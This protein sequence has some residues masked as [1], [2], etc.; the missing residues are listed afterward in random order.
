MNTKRNFL[1]T[2]MSLFAMIVISSCDKNDDDN[3]DT[4]TNTISAKWEI[5]DSNSAYASFEFNKDG[6]YIVIENETINKSY[7]TGKSKSSLFQNGKSLGTGNIATRSASAESNL[8][9]IHYGTYKIEENRIILTGFGV[10][11][12]ISIT[13]EEFTFS[14]ILEATGAKGVYV[15]SKA[16]EPISASNR[17]DMFCRTWKAQKLSIDESLVPDVEKTYFI[18][19][20]GENWKAGLEKSANEERVGTIVLFSKAGTYLVLYT[21]GEAGL[22][23]WRWTNKE[24]KALYYSWDNWED[25]WENNIVQINKLSDSTLEI[26]EEFWIYE[27]VLAK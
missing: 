10:I 12:V 9:P 2:L 5:T 8:S 11:D 21:D 3:G 15:A 22:S 19:E 13:T 23:E 4:L 26:Q 24:E 27:F 16:K 1:M 7:V 25:D 18:N 20:F 14:F 17:T 6:N